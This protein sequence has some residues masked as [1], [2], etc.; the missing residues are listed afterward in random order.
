[1]SPRDGA[2]S[3]RSLP[4]LGGR[5]V[6]VTGANSGIGYEAALAFAGAGAHVVLA[7]RNE[8]LG[9]AALEAIRGRH[10]AASVE[11]GHL[12]LAELAS[13]RRFAEDV[14]RR[15]ARLDLL[16]NNAGV[17]ALPHRR[18]VDGFEMQLG[19]NHLGHFALTG[20]LL[21]RLLATE[22]SRV[23]TVSS[24][25]HHF[26][27]IRFDD[28]HGERRYHPWLAYGQAKL[29]NLLF[30]YELQRRLAAAGSATLSVACHPGY[31][32][33]NLQM[34]GARMEKARVRERL[35]QLVNRTVAQSTA[36]GAL[37]TLYAAVA[38]DVAGGDYIGP[39]GLFELFGHPVKVASNRRSRDPELAARLWHESEALTGVSYAPLLR[40]PR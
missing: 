30:A 20:C 11:L 5:V 37:P 32:N 27:T 12:D 1:M 39:R 21:E 40:S 3:A 7:C 14:A 15:H 4:E 17:M 22:G 10:P 35:W 28:L 31:A 23:V 25:A 34:G 2:W 19:T 18:T 16:V 13:I 33:T 26:G 29:A 24:L 36:M 38:V 6:V 8:T 9:A